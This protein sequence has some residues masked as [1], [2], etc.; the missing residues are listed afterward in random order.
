MALQV[1]KD[2]KPD[3]IRHSSIQWYTDSQA[4]AALLSAMKG[5]AQCLEEVKAVYAIPL[6]LE[7]DLVWQWRPRTHELL[8]VA[9]AHSKD[10]RYSKHQLPASCS[11]SIAKAQ[12]EA[13]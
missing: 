5:D 1:L 3:S 2:S 11:S 12:L 8:V 6:E 4:G 10:E 7:L 13:P 9:D